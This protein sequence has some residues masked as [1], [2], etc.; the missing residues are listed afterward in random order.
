MLQF[1]EM[2]SEPLRHRYKTVF[3]R[4]CQGE[5]TNL[6]W[7]WGGSFGIENN[8]VCVLRPQ[9]LYQLCPQMTSANRI[10][11]GLIL[12]EHRLC[13][14]PFGV[15]RNIMKYYA[16]NRESSEVV[17]CNQNYS[18]TLQVGG[19]PWESELRTVSLISL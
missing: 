14:S 5:S 15:S 12:R 13:G 4:I 18:P 7:D 17:T 8:R 9:N 1:K 19:R 16:A 2:K 10:N 3:S 11:C 6:F